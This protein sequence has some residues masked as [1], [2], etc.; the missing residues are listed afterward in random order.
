MAMPLPSFDAASSVTAVPATVTNPLTFA[1]TCSGSDRL[2]LVFP[3]TSAAVSVFTAT[4]ASYNSVAMTE[5]PSSG[6]LFTDGVHALRIQCF[7]LIAPDTGSNTVS[8]T[9]DAMAGSDRVIIAASFSGVHQSSP[10]GTAGTANGTS[11][12]S[13]L[14]VS[15]AS[16]ELVVAGEIG[17]QPTIFQNV[18]QTLLRKDENINFETAAAVASAFGA[19]SVNN[20]FLLGTGG[21]ANKWASTGVPLKPL[22][23]TSREIL[24]K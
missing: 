7:Y 8:V 18:L 17:F 6:S 21:V 24:F 5:V 15:S 12:P 10:I 19:A 20:G 9:W 1:H 22:D 4:S 2:L 11:N 23:P 14:S 3:A 16:G 13:S